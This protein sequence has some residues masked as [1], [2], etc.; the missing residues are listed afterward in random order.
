MIRRSSLKIEIGRLQSPDLQVF[1][2][3][4]I[5]RR[6]LWR[7]FKFQNRIHVSIHR[8]FY[9]VKIPML[10]SGRRGMSFIEIVGRECSGPSRWQ[11][12]PTS[13]TLGLDTENGPSECLHFFIF[14]LS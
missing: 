7:H 11:R 2:V 3:G 4:P 13:L 6:T 1:S 5:S 14:T 8:L 9:Y 12:I 10:H